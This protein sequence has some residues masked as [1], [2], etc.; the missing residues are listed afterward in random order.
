MSFEVVSDFKG[1][2]FGVEINSESIFYSMSFLHEEILDRPDIFD[3]KINIGQLV[4]DL[5]Y[6]FA[7]QYYKIDCLVTE[8]ADELAGCLNVDSFSELRFDVF[9]S[10]FYFTDINEKIKNGDYLAKNT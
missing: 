5:L 4:I 6:A 9:G 8:I 10:D 7:Q 2:V 3:D 1:K